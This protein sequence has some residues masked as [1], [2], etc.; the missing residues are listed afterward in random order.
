MQNPN[1]LLTVLSSMS[2]KPEVQFDKLFQKLYNVELWLMAYQLIAPRQGNMTKGVDGTTIDGT[3]RKRIEKIIA[4]LKASRY[5]PKPARRVYIPKA[6]GKLRPLGI[7]S[8]EDKLLQTVVKL[9]LEAI[10]EP[11]FSPNSHGFRPSRSCHTAL[12]QIKV[13]KGVRWWIEADIKGFFDN[14]QHDTLLHI[15]S[16]RIT[17]KRFLHLISQFLQAGYVETGIH[18]D[19]YSGTPQGGNLSPILSNIYLHELDLMIQKKA[20]LVLMML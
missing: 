2:C 19:T 15:L 1:I 4:D 12:E 5:T 9:I 10:Y 13:M 20:I 3:G 17:D 6:N 7:P 14:L 8:F 16:K 18:H 11:I